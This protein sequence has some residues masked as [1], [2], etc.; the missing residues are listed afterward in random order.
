M[1]NPSKHRSSTSGLMGSHRRWLVRVVY[2]V[3]AGAFL[4]F[5]VIQFL[6]GGYLLATVEL[7]SALGLSIVTALIGR[8]RHLPFWTYTYLLAVGAFLMLLISS[9]NA[10]ST[11][12]VWL[13]LMPVLAYLLL[14]RPGGPVIA[15]PFIVVGLALWRDQ[16]GPFT[17]PQDVL[18][19][20]NPVLCS[21][22]MLLF[23][24][25]YEGRRA[26]AERQLLVLAETDPLTGVANRGYFRATLDR[27]AHE[28]KRS[29]VRFSLVLVDID[30]FKRVNDTLG[31]DAGDE[32][33]RWITQNL[34]ERL[35]GTDFIGR[36]G[37]EEFGIILR[38][39]DR[40][41]ARALVETLRERIEAQPIQYHGKPIP[42]TASFGIAHWPDDSEDVPTLYQTAD[43]RMYRSKQSGRNRVSDHDSHLPLN[44]SDAPSAGV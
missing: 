39:A 16:L 9:P 36:L 15:L 4:A 1:R 29:G 27:T 44:S 18:T 17:T 12:F 21:L 41:S 25:L 10:A 30:H 6:N 23:V 37:G 5:A 43:R 2:G 14:G 8:T 31:H 7:L 26:E 28:S 3:S 33:L 20:M 40:H 35:R 34:E 19:F 38:D 32:V 13:L 22:L 42:I 11:A 24:H